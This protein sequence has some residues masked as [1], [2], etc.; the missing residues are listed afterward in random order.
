MRLLLIGTWVSC[1]RGPSTPPEGASS[2]PPPT[3]VAST[4]PEAC[5]M[6][7]FPPH[8]SAAREA[9]LP[10]EPVLDDPAVLQPHVE[11]ST[12]NPS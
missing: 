8:I 7:D 6:L 9:V 11:T 2:P 12:V 10:V 3:E 4:R 5:P 1:A